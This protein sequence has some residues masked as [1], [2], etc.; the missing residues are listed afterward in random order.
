M[1]G[2][3]AFSLAPIVVVVAASALAA[4]LA[5]RARE[6]A[7]QENRRKEQLRNGFDGSP[8]P[9]PRRRRPRERGC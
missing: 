8:R 2:P 9:E 4:N 7:E 3:K 1:S 5:E 6:D